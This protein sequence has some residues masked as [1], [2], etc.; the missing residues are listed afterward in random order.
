MNTIT[1]MNLRAP[2]NPYRREKAPALTQLAWADLSE[3]DFIEKVADIAWRKP[4]RGRYGENYGRV[5]VSSSKTEIFIRALGN[6][7]GA[8]FRRVHEIVF[9]RA[10]ER[11]AEICLFWATEIHEGRMTRRDIP[12]GGVARTKSILKKLKEAV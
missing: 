5:G 12:R 10:K 1:E 4:A 3:E 8:D 6:Y 7:R 11:F 9:R 2:I